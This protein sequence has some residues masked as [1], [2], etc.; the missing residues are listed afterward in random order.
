MRKL[1][2]VQGAGAIIRLLYL[3]GAKGLEKPVNSGGMMVKANSQ[4]EA[5]QNR[6]MNAYGKI[7]FVE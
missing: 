7:L 4:R 2:V 6:P 3:L 5:T 1:Y